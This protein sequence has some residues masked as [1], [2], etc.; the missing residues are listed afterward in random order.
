MNSVGY[1]TP[2]GSPKERII[3][4]APNRNKRARIEE[5]ESEDESGTFVTQ[6]DEIL[7]YVNENDEE[8]SKEIIKKEDKKE[9]KKE[10]KN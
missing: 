3:P 5:E 1:I 4:P 7:I 9:E 2:P 10:E 6:G 8:I